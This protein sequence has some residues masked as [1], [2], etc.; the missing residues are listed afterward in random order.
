MQ[1]GGGESELSGMNVDA[2]AQVKSG[3]VSRSPVRAA[4]SEMNGTEM[5]L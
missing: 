3:V 2:S 1:R 5:S 4:Q